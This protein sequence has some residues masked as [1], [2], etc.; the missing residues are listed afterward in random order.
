M[1]PLG[2]F[3]ATGALEHVTGAICA[4]FRNGLTVMGEGSQPA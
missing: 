3:Q 2:A 1:A 4:N